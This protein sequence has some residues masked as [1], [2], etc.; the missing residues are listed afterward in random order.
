MNKLYFSV[1]SRKGGVGKTTVALNMSQML[2]KKGYAVLMLD[3][4]ITGT[5]SAEASENSEFWKDDIN[6]IKHID[7]NDGK[8]KPLNLL[9]LFCKRK[10]NDENQEVLNLDILD[11]DKEKINM[12]PDMYKVFVA[13]K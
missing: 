3:C 13:I 10:S 8:E 7:K 4:D 12:I 11:Y 9:S 5:S 6:V 2:L 1:E